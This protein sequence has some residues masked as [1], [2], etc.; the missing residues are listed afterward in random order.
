[1]FGTGL[2]DPQAERPPDVEDVHV[3]CVG[4]GLGAF[5]V[6]AADAGLVLADLGL[7]DTDLRGELDAAVA[8]VFPGFSELL[9][10]LLLLCGL[11]APLVGGRHLAS[12]ARRALRNAHT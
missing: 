6:G 9:A 11:G 8:G 5:V 12:V 3:E 1:M 10:G 2:G 7:P 4:D